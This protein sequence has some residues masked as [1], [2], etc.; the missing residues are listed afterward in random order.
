MAIATNSFNYNATATSTYKTGKYG[1]GVDNTTDY[2]TS[3]STYILNGV[4]R[5]NSRQPAVIKLGNAELTE[6]TLHKLLAL[7]EV[8]EGADNTEL[9][10]LLSTVIAL[11][12]ISA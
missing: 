6:D 4:D 8:I 9:N 7:L 11:R 2:T 3:T 1:I 10:T 12:K 5:I